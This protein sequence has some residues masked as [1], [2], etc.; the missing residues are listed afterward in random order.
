M[1]WAAWL[2]LKWRYRTTFHQRTNLGKI[3]ATITAKRGCLL[4]SKAEPIPKN[5][6]AF[7]TAIWKELAAEIGSAL[8]AQI[9]QQIGAENKSAID[10]AL[11]QFGQKLNDFEQRNEKLMAQQ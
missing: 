11:A 8:S 2:Y 5:T 10:S 3:I 6:L 9:T 4:K 7:A 1:A